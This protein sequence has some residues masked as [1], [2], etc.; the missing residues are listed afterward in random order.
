[1][2]QALA[3]FTPSAHDPW[4][5]AKAAHLLNRAG[6]GGR[7]DEVERVVR[8]GLDASVDDLIHFDRVPENFPPPDFSSLRTLW[9][10]VATLY[11]N[12]APERQRFEAR[13]IAQRAD[14]EKLVELRHWWIA[15][16]IQTRRPLQEKMV[17]FW[18]GLL[19]SGRPD[20]RLTENLYAQN[21]LFRRHALGNF[22]AL[23]LAIC[24]DPAMLEYLDNE[25]NRKGRPNEN[26]ARELLELFTMGVGHYTERD[27]KE[28]ARAFTG[29]TRRGFEFFF[30]ARQHDDGVKTFLGRTGP[31]DGGDIVDIIFEQPATARFLPRRLFEA[32]AYLR[33]EEELVE[34]LARIF[35]DSHFEVAPV[36]RAILT[37]KAFYSPKAMRTQV[38]SPA[39]LVI[40]T[41]R[42]LDLDPAQVPLLARAMDRAGQSLFFPP[43]VGGWPRGESWITT[44]TM[45]ARY[46]LSGLVL[47][48]G[49][50]GIARRPAA[51]PPLPP[52]A[53]R[54]ADGA[55]TA[56][57]VVDRLADALVFGGP[58]ERRRGALVRALGASAPD[59]P[60]ALSSP[61]AEAKFRSMLHLLMCSP[62]YQLA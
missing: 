44:A 3:R 25:S 38:K 18:H 29:W 16:M 47:T 22:K 28:A 36:V 59:A 40:G 49:A 19:V 17:L 41:A 56:G 54:I 45:L 9:E 50:P 2:Q 34:D 13:V 57:E 14:N 48:G 6:F 55:R 27:V 61:E 10:S 46:N 60:F 26:F 7:P 32:F 33:P 5:R 58:D 23:V 35:R 4:D 53:V 51:P 20:A 52:A 39:Q 37:S 62:E 24:K 1:M 31:W 42:L 12:R 11:R 15:R 21:E 43:N 30:D 8:M